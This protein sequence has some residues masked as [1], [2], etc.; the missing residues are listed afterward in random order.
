MEGNRDEAKRCI[1]IACYSLKA[2]NLEKARKFLLKAEKLYPSLQAQK[3][4]KEIDSLDEEST[5]NEPPKREE[6]PPEVKYTQEQVDLVKKVKK[7]KNF[8][9][10]LGVTKDSTDSEIRKAYKKLAL[11]LHPDK[12]NAPGAAEAFKAV[13]NAVAVL[14]DA[15]KR[16]TYDLYGEKSSSGSGSAR[17]RHTHD[18]YRQFESEATAEELFNMFFG[19]GFSS[20]SGHRRYHNHRHD[21]NQPSLAFGLIL[22]LVVVSLMSTFLTSDPIYS[23]QQT[24]KYPIARKTSGLSI[25]YYVKTNFDEEYTGPLARLE[26][27]VEEE[28][29]IGMKKMCMRER[30]Y[31]EAMMSRA[32]HFGNKVQFA[33]AQSLQTPSCDTL[34]RIGKYTF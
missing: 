29:L 25:S 33:Q 5:H 14:T 28:Y 34:Y 23:L 16:K 3:L 24:S 18:Y 8:Y 6:E 20:H 32:Q 2:G 12:N 26:L 4:L 10:M 17:H 22:V 1:D 19:D 31:K 30:H 21:N 11:H 7:C 9:E 13:G 27:S 15:E